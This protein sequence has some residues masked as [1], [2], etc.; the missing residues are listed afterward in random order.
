MPLSRTMST[1]LARLDARLRRRS[2]IG[3]ALGMAVYAFVI[4]ALY[5]TFK[6][7]SSLNEFTKGG[8]KLAALFG[9]SGPLTTPPGWLNAN[10]YA[11]FLPLVVLLLTI[12]YGAFAIAGQD[13]DGTLGVLATLPVT[14]RSLLLQKAATMVLL[15]VP[16]S[17]LTMM[18]VLTGRWF[19]LPIGSANLVGISVGALLLGVDFGA[20]ALLLGAITGSRGTTLGITSAL[21]AAAYLISS[22]APVVQ[23]IRPARYASP[24]YYAVGNGQLVNRLGWSSLVVLVV[25]AAVL[26]TGAVFAFERLDIH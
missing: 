20:L 11:N 18:V 24:F 2:M 19:Q 7:D 17:L 21:A 12:G 26:L 14:R 10:V 23:W 25:T 13:E 15:G 3:Y 16:V 9:A 5:P 22:L 6:D 1:E 4:V 8:S